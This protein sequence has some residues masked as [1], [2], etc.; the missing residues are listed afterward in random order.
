MS[1][2]GGRVRA[3]SEEMAGLKVQWHEAGDDP[4]PVLYVHGQPNHGAQWR[5]FMEHT[6]GLA[7]DLPGFGASGKP[8]H[9]PY[10]IQG[11]GAW[12][13][14]FLEARGVDRY[15]LVVHDWGA[16]GLAAAQAAPERVERLVVIDAVP[17]LSGYRWLLMARLWRRRLVGELAMG[18]TTK[19]I[20]RRLLATLDGRAHPDEALDEVWRHFDHG[21]Q[22]AILRLYRSAPPDVLARAGERLHTLEAP[23]LILWGGDDRFLEPDFAH[24]YADA[25]GG[26]AEVEVLAGRGHW[27]WL[28][29]PSVVERVASFLEG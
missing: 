5:P 20:M 13:E 21:T 11:Y 7:P 18:A 23:T 19:A 29:D 12:I 8:G 3:R 2:H 10:D 9:F 26:D 14:A 4:V 1:E 15:R 17:F 28:E 24:R 22:R 27:P 16:V 25:L 6:G